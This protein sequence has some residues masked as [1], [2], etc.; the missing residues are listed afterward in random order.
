MS[1]KSSVTV[2]AGSAIAQ[3]HRLATPGGA[4]PT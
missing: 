4:T 3:R 2:P 1:L